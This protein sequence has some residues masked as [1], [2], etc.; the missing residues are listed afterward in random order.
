M[1]RVQY[2]PSFYLDAANATDWYNGRHEGLGDDFLDELWRLTRQIERS[3]Q[4]FAIIDD[5][6]RVGQL[7]RFPY[8]VYFEIGEHEI[9]IFGVL[10]LHRDDMAWQ[11]R[12]P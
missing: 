6:V 8:G 4:S 11:E 5:A 1:D 7:R 10:H 2:R 3:P 9:V 12:R